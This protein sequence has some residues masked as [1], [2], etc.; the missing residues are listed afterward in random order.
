MRKFLSGCVLVMMA[1]CTGDLVEIGAAA[2]QDMSVGGAA[3]MAQ[4]GG[5]ELGPNTAKFFP[6]IQA[7][8]DSLGCSASVCHGAPATQIPLMKMGAMAGTDHQ[9]YTD[10]MGDVNLTAPSQSKVLTKNLPGAS[11]GG[12]AKFSGTSDP[13][14]VRWLGWISAGA[15]EQ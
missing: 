7:D 5:G 14:Y 4:G 1:G 3:D 10:F 11:H 2:K 8:L 9:Y 15:P 12:G 13:V 6:N